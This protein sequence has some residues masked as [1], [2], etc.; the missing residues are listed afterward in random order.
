MS[1]RDGLSRGSRL[2]TLTALSVSFGRTGQDRWQA[3]QAQRAPLPLRDSA[4]AGPG[5]DTVLGLE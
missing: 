1:G 2:A 3:G 4:E 5:V